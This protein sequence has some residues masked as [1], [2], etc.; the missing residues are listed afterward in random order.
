[1]SANM[2]KAT[3][4]LKAAALSSADAADMDRLEGGG[5]GLRGRGGNW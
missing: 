5:G 4:L 1:M 2:V 3:G